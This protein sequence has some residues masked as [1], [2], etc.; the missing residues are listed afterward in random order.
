A[1]CP[2]RRSCSA[3]P[4]SAWPRDARTQRQRDAFPGDSDMTHF[5]RSRGNR[6][7]RAARRS[8]Y[9]PVLEALE[10]REVP[11][12]FTVTRLADD[13]LAGSLRWAITQ[14]NTMPGD[15]LIN[16]QAGLSGTIQL[17]GALPNLSSNIDLQGPGASRLT[18]RR[19]TG[20]DYGIF[21]VASGAAV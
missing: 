10:A 5:F 17:A 19:H 16:F 15:D 2:R 3:S 11:A 21:T 8:S 20:G 9:R 12:T 7:A 6:L 18:V 13:A 1:A 4:R 14:A